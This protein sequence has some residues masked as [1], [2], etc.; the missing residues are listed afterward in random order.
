MIGIHPDID[1]NIYDDKE[2]V[3]VCEIRKL[4]NKYYL[5]EE[6]YIDEVSK[7]LLNKNS[8]LYKFLA[9]NENWLTIH[10]NLKY[11]EKFKKKDDM[12]KKLMQFEI[13]QRTYRTPS[14]ILHPV[15]RKY[16]N[17]RT[18]ERDLLKIFLKKKRELYF[19]T[20]IDFFAWCN[21]CNE[22]LLLLDWNCAWIVQNI[23]KINIFEN[24]GKTN[25]EID[26]LADDLEKLNNKIGRNND[27]Y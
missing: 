25:K 9:Y 23:I 6:E 18:R 21:K 22:Y 7:M 16:Y 20:G 8:T 3:M 24:S 11:D 26:G 14:E 17:F 27:N 10:Y 1:I 5:S 4:L 12:D 13:R 19:I 15:Y 2:K